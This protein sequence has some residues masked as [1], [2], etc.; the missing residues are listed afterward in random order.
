MRPA[1]ALF[2]IGHSNHSLAHF[3]LLL[4]QHGITA[5]A[6]VRSSP[7]SRWHPQFSRDNLSE[8]LH[9]AAEIEYVFLGRQLGAR[10]DEAELLTADGRV[11]F[12]RLG[13]SLPFQNG[14]KRILK[15]L[16]SHR[17]A[18]MCAERDPLECHRGILIAP[19]VLPL[20]ESLDHIGPDGG[21]ETHQQ[22]EER[23]LAGLH[24]PNR[25][26]FRTHAELLRE[27]YSRQEER[28]AWRKDVP[29]SQEPERI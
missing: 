7:Y 19:R 16:E 12:E 1:P 4:R 2:T 22:A 21:L 25:D 26:L 28:I 9:A 3:V 17:I 11:D 10:P 18:L 27:A 6:D 20:V 24:L 29:D 23:L 8:A 13:G 14:V 5:V 15:G